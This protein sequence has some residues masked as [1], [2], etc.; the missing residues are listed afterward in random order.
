MDDPGSRSSQPSSS[1]PHPATVGAARTEIETSPEA[2]DLGVRLDEHHLPE[3]N[4][5]MAVC[6]RCG[7]RTDNPLGLQHVPDE[8]QLA[9]GRA[10]LDGQIRDSRIARL[11]E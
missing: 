11:S 4:G 9:R 1:D 10:W 6:R 8:R 2:A 7:A 5:R 3:T